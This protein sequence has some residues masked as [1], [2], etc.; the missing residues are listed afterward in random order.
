MKGPT[1][2]GFYWLAL[3][4]GQDF[5]P[6]EP[7]LCKVGP[8]VGLDISEGVMVKFLSGNKGSIEAPSLAD[9][10]SGAVR[11]VNWEMAMVYTIVSRGEER[12]LHWLKEAKPP[13]MPAAET[14]ANDATT[15]NV[16][17]L[18]EQYAGRAVE[19]EMGL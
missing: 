9:L 17:A 5:D 16:A 14:A 13:K 11:R 10:Q 8:Y 2:A 15:P 12:R 3:D 18:A 19:R 7:I 4:D 1:K 6:P